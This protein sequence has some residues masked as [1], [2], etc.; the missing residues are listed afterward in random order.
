MQK[1]DDILYALR[2]G[3]VIAA[4]ED[5]DC[6]PLTGGVSSDIWRIDLEAGPV[7]VKRALAKLKVADD[8]R[9]PV[10]RN[11]FEVAWMQAVRKIAPDAVPEII[12]HD[13][14]SGL[15]AMSFLGPETA[16][17]WKAQLRDGIADTASADAVGHILGRIHTATSTDP[18]I[19]PRFD[20]DEIF[21]A[22]RLEP[23]L[24]ATAERCPDVAARL[25]E[26][27]EITASNKVALVHGDVSPKNI[28]IGPKGPVFLDAEC[29]WHGD[30][31]FDLAFCLN[32]LLLKC[33]WNPAARPG[34]KAC[35]ETLCLSYESAT[36]E[37]ADRGIV[38][39][40]AHL[41]A[42]LFLARID[43]KSPAEYITEDA[44]KNHVRQ[45]ARQFLT[46]PADHPIDISDAW[47]AHLKQ[48]Q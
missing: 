27:S 32:H 4:G 1:P 45:I 35:F 17:V 30:P 34:F 40:T 7:C 5:P 25:R 44:D 21:H 41:L 14:E 26:L 19:P 29:A 48:N 20:N 39:R 16:P 18:D 37:M 12:F 43:G 38:L 46:N 9:A 3:G 33:L 13:P 47:H 6:T 11:A 42:G 24:L 31:A 2:R 28:L 8:W 23:Y 36:A 22:I 15:F 10:S